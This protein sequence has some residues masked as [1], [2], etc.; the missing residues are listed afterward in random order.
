[1]LWGSIIAFAIGVLFN[2][3]LT[4]QI[5]GG[6]KELIGV[7]D[8]LSVG[9]VD[10]SITVDAKAKDEILDKLKGQVS[11]LYAVGDAKAPRLIRHA[12]SEAYVTAFHL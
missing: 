1:M 4:R 6:V 9:D 7:A 12:I 8:T 5:T 3:Y 10:V 11:D 2:L